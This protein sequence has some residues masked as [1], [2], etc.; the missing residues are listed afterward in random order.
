MSNIVWNQFLEKRELNTICY[1]SYVD[2]LI[3]A[4]L[5]R[6]RLKYRN[7]ACS[8]PRYKK[9]C[10]SGRLW[11]TAIHIKLEKNTQFINRIKGPLRC[12]KTFSTVDVSF[13][14]FQ[15]VLIRAKERFLWK[16]FFEICSRKIFFF[17]ITTLFWATIKDKWC[18][19][20]S[21]FQM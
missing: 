11:R 18:S 15:S 5:K 14:N 10:V 16:K 12:I 21:L 20:W 9:S 8:S 1:I 13:S 2:I 17:E 7:E 19:T 3:K 6:T 4:M